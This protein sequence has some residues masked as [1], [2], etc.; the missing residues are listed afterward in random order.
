[1]PR[2]TQ[3]SLASE[4]GIEPASENNRDKRVTAALAV[5]GQLIANTC[6]WWLIVRLTGTRVDRS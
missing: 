3:G 5:G 4:A 6:G 1:M 2:L